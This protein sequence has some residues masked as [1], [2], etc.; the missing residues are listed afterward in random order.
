[1]RE[2]DQRIIDKG[3]PSL[4]LMEEAARAFTRRLQTSISAKRDS[5]WRWQQRR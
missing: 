1:M 3:V 2:I 4:L 5:V